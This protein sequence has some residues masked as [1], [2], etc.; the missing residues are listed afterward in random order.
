MINTE[1]LSNTDL[2][3]VNA[4]KLIRNAYL[5]AGIPAKYHFHDLETSWSTEYSPMQKLS[6]L[7]KKRSIFVKKF[8]GCYLQNIDVVL[9]GSGI[10][11][12]K[13]KKIKFIKDLV[14]IGGNS[15]GKTLLLSLIAQ[16]A[17]NNGSKTLFINWADFLHKYQSYNIAEEDEDLFQAALNCDLLLIDSIRDYDMAGTRNFQVL[18]DRLITKRDINDKVTIVSIDTTEKQELPVYQFAW[19]QF[20]RNTPQIRLPEASQNNEIKS[21]RS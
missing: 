17:I 15:S 3:E 1:L 20:V 14:F 7:G 11:Y 6:E 2:V 4:K 16:T 5:K 21:K 19:N 13:N 10:K 12:T 18:L 9:H 8:L